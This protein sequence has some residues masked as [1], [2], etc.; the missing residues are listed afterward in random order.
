MKLVEMRNSVQNT[1]LQV[2]ISFLDVFE[3]FLLRVDEK[4]LKA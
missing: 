2:L 4:Q 1:S 3:T